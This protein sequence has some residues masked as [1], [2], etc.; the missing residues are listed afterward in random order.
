ML[1]LTSPLVHWSLIEGFPAISPSYG[2]GTAG[3]SKQSVLR[4]CHPPAKGG[5]PFPTL[6]QQVSMTVSLGHMT[7]KKRFTARLK[8]AAF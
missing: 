2:V 1:L 4:L 5:I 8:H 7:V 6:Y 3:S